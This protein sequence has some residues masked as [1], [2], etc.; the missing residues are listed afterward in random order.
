MSMWTTIKGWFSS[1]PE[2]AP[3]PEAQAHKTVD[4]PNGRVA[5]VDEAG[6]FIRFVTDDDL[7]GQ[8]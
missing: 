8:K 2:P 7:P 5:L 1:K 3:A 4:L 6:N